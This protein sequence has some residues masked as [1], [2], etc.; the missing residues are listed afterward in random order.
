MMG[1]ATAVW[2]WDN[3]RK[4]LHRW[5]WAGAVFLN[6]AAIMNSGSR[7]GLLG[8]WVAA[9]FFF[10]PSRQPPAEPLRRRRDVRGRDGA[11]RRHRAPPRVEPPG[12]PA[13]PGPADQQ[14]GLLRPG[15]VPAPAGRPWR[16]STRTPSSATAS[17]TSS[18]CTSPTCRAGWLPGPSPDSSHAAWAWRC[19]SFPWSADR[20]T[21]HWAAAPRRSPPRGCSPT[22]S[23]RATS[24]CSWRSRSAPRSR[25]PCWGPAAARPWPASTRRR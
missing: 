25:S 14:R 8:I 18:T 13:H 5:F 1:C 22:S 10:A 17:A 9:M 19:S 11:A 6:L 3:A 4:P 2:L 21:W 23:P 15:A 7:G 20:E 24:G 16:G 12:P